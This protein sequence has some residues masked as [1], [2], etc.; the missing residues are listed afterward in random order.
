MKHY[1]TPA[2]QLYEAGQE[3]KRRIG[4]YERVRENERFYRGEQWTRLENDLPH[5]VF[6]LVRRIT[7]YLVC[8]VLPGD[9]SVQ[10]TDDK[11]PFL[12]SEALRKNVSEGLRILN[13]NASYRWKR[14]GMR[15][16]AHKALHNAALTGDGIFYC[17]WDGSYR[18]GQPFVGDI[19]TDLINNTD[20]FVA[21]VN[22]TDLQSQEYLILSGRATLSSLRREAMANGAS[23]RDAMS[24]VGDGEPSETD[25]TAFELSCSPKATF[26][27][28][29]FRENGEVIFEKSTRERV[30]CRVNTGLKYYPVAYFNWHPTKGSFHGTPVVSDMI[31]NQKYINTAYAMVMKHMYD[32]AFS[33]IIYD[34]S[35][36]PEWSNEVGQAIAAMG[37]GN[38]S[39]A[40]SVVGVGKMQEGY[41]ELIANVIETTKDIMGATEAALG[42]A[43]ANNTSA[44]L[45]LQEAS[46]LSL[47][48]VASDFC[49]CIGELATIWAD[50][51]CT[52]CP[53]ERLLVTEADGVKTAERINYGLL[54][55]ELLRANV[56]VA[57][58]S[59][60]TPAATVSVLDKLLERGDLDVTQYLELLPPGTVEN[61][62]SMLRSILS[63][64]VNTN[65]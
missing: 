63:K 28:R 19:R 52:Y 53:P 62:E 21:D 25:P 58:V 9:L 30:I 61:R 20:L 22:S 24:I 39:D 47:Q 23:E 49:R 17:W 41:L 34:K 64:G 5:P 59:T 55:E 14:N 2:W 44:I 18:D 57:N 56:E 50:M 32:T 36:I 31:A 10:Y 65:E 15:A 6:N 54:K 43:P 26:L 1:N 35:R 8:A 46:K 16:L 60:Y 51:L 7:D 29:F 45:T 33:K 42:D 12:E 11:F 37:G 4:L 48:Q 40:V 38:V 3:Y 13:S 27:I